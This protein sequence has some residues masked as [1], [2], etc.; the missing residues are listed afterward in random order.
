MSLASAP[1]PVK[2]MSERQEMLIARE[3]A[4]GADEGTELIGAGFM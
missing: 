1:Y 2:I 4:Q 3:G